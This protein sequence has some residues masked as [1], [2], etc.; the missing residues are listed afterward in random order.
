LDVATIE[1]GTILA[2]DAVNWTAD[3]QLVGS[4]STVLYDVPVAWHIDST[5]I[6]A[7]VHCMVV[8]AADRRAPNC[9]VI[10]LYSGVAP[11]LLLVF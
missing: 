7:A 9:L 8:V 5:Q 11:E 3:V 1:R 10:G 2:F 6:V 4:M